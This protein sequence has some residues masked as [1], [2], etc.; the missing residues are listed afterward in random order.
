MRIARRC[1]RI[2]QACFREEEWIDADREFYLIVR[3]ELEAIRESAR[4]GG[5]A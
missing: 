4:G 1:R 5:K 3:E 2:V